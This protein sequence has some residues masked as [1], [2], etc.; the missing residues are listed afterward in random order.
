MFVTLTNVQSGGAVSLQQPIDNRKGSLEVAIRSFTFWIGW[1]NL[2]PGEFVSWRKNGETNTLSLSQGLYSFDLLAD[3]LSGAEADLSLN[4]DHFSGRVNFT[5]PRDYE[6]L[7]S[8]NLTSLLGL[9]KGWMTGLN[10]AEGPINMTPEKALYVHL[11]QL[12]TSENVVDGAPSTLL[13]VFPAPSDPFGT[14]RN[15][16][17]RPEWKKLAAGTTGE[18][19]IRVTDER[20]ALLDNNGQPISVVLEIRETK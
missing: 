20:Q 3:T 16:N 9:K 11:D 2:K 5:V 17:P 8:E 6:V 13:A 14:T 19:K 12:S 10:F 7:L 15:W 18:L 1:H 4:V